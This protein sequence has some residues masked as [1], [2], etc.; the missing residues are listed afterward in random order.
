VVGD[1][2]A[3]Y[4]GARLQDDTL[5]PAGSAWTGKVGFEQW[6]RQSGPAQDRAA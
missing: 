2:L 3:S 6:L 1:A 4:F 5:V